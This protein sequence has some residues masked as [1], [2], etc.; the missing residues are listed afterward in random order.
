MRTK[1]LRAVITVT[2][3]LLTVSP[4][5]PE[6]GRS[7]RSAAQG[8]STAVG[9]PRVARASAQ[10]RNRLAPYRGL[11][12]WIDIYDR[13]K[14]RHPYRTVA[15]LASRQVRTIFLQ[16]ANYGSRG[17]IKF[18]GVT[19]RFLQAAH[20]RG[21]HV[22]GW[23]VPDFVRLRRDLRRSVAAV[24]FR[25]RGGEQFDSF[26]LDIEANILPP[27]RRTDRLLRLSRQLRKASGRGYPLGAIT[28]SPR[29][30]EL[31]PQFW[32][33]FPYARLARHFDV[34]IPMAYWTYQAGSR[35]GAHR[36]I[37]RSVEL[38]RMGTG[39]PRV[40]IH[41]IGGLAGLAGPAEVR[42]FVRAIQ[43]SRVIG[44][45]LYDA[46]T[47]SREDW[48]ILRGLGDGQAGAFSIP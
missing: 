15:R 19:T 38:I 22:V 24:R 20:A 14:W 31:Y 3:A 45:S 48:A 33:G 9:R 46:D 18:P 30:M 26:A 37:A 13:A 44:A 6:L 42:G 21:L 2:A 17:P 1:A 4:G 32:P 28:P 29:G 39:R 36:Y 11:G 34:F 7:L 5:A 43:R 16:T 47:S 25:G 8:W 10:H 12:A 41:M 23:Y 35:W 27:G 40:P